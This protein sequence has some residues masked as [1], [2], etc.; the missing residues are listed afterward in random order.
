[1]AKLVDAL[2]ATKGQLAPLWLRM[3]EKAQGRRKKSQ[4]P[5]DVEAD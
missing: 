4:K 1:V 2:I 3:D 5:I